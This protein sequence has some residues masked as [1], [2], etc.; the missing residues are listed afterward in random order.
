[1]NL[2]F[3]FDDI[4]LPHACGLSRASKRD[5]LSF[6]EWLNAQCRGNRSTCNHNT[7][8]LV[9]AMNSFFTATML[10]VSR[11]RIGIAST[12][13][14]RLPD[15]FRPLGGGAMMAPP[16]TGALLAFLGCV[17]LPVTHAGA[18]AGHAVARSLDAEPW[19]FEA[20]PLGVG[21]A[22]RWYGGTSPRWSAPSP[23]LGHGSP[24][25]SATRRR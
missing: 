22:E 7:V 5:E 24:R 1:M 25:T 3:Q 15:L 8:P 13:A 23:P 20:D 2:E 21:V 17:S 19:E 18:A 10:P 4:R 6:S 16:T 14:A 11:L 9:H 12:A